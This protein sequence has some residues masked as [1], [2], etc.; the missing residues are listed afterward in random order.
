MPGSLGDRSQLIKLMLLGSDEMILPLCGIW[1]AVVEVPPGLLEVRA[2][3]GGVR[4]L[5]MMWFR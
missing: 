1:C 5:R 4:W 3:K 2:G